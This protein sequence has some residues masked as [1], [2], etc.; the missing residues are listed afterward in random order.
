MST[1]VYDG[2]YSAEL[3]GDE[4]V[5]FLIG[6]RINRLWALRSWLPVFAA[7]PRMLRELAVHPELGM[8]G[9]RTYVSGR[10]IMVVQYW[11]SVD[12]LHA[13]SRAPDHLHLPA[14]KAFRRAAAGTGAVGIFHETYRV[15]PGSFETVYSGMPAFGLADATHHVSA[16][17]LGRSARRRLYRTGVDTP[18]V[19]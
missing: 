1:T 5:A 7:M 15:T 10:V 2:R 19:G 3:D 4:R 17:R 12:D 9:A 18:A 16:D 6:M 13:Y 11:R 14:W 8:L